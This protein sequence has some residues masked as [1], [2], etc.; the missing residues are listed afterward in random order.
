MVLNPP[1]FCSQHGLFPVTAI[2]IDPGVTGTTFTDCGATCPRCGR[3]SEIIPGVY[4]ATDDRLNILIDSSISPEALSAVRQLAER[5]QQGTITSVQAK[6][7]AEKI[8]PRLGKLFDVWNWSDQAKATLWAAIL[9]GA[10]VI[11]AA[12]IASAPSQTVIVQ[13]TIERT[14][15]TKELLLSSSALSSPQVPLPRPRPKRP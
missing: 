14:I 1:A 3:V 8:L 7:E 2:A 13:P 10:A 5:L 9:G 12:R 15:E 4:D 6:E 11:Q